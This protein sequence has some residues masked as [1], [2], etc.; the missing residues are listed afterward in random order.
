MFNRWVR[1]KAFGRGSGL[2]IRPVCQQARRSSDDISSTSRVRM[3]AARQG[4]NSITIACQG[5]PCRT[6][7][8]SLCGLQRKKR[9]RSD[10]VC[11]FLFLVQRPGRAVHN[12][13]LP[14]YES[15][16]CRASRYSFCTCCYVAKTNMHAHA[17]RWVPNRSDSERYRAAT[18]L[19]TVVHDVATMRLALQDP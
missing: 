15:N 8:A 18:T 5:S 9:R 12:V 6:G 7:P 1:A 11:E 17:L 19:V 16:S 14:G 4:R 2:R 10:S 13:T 3:A